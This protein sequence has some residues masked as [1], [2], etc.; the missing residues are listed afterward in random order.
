MVEP[1]ESSAKEVV[2][3]SH[4]VD[5]DVFG[6]GLLKEEFLCRVRGVVN[7]VVKVDANV[8]FVRNGI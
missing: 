4:E 2:Y 6:E 1:V 5:A 7:K 8:E 3:F